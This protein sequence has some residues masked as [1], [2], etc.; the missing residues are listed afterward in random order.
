L[1]HR[2]PKELSVEIIFDIHMLVLLILPLLF[3]V[4]LNPVNIT[5]RRI[6]FLLVPVKI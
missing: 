2:N 3:Y 4:Q 1:V 5:G 6:S